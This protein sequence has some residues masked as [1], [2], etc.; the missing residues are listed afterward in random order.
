MTNNI[1]EINERN[2]YIINII[3]NTLKNETTRKILILSGRVEH[4]K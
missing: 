1:V 4:C 2:E 3:N